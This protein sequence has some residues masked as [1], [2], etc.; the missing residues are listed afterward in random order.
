MEHSLLCVLTDKVRTK[1][2][3]TLYTFG[4]PRVGQISYAR[5]SSATNTD[6]YRCTHGADPVPLIPCALFVHAPYCG[7]EYRLDDGVGV[8][9]SAHGM[10]GNVTSRV[11]KYCK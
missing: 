7:K 1:I 4:A 9:F 3:T 5:K 10:D 11:F 2:T 8:Y 6:I